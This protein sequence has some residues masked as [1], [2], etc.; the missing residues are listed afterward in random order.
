[1]TLQSHSWAYIQRKKMIRKETCTP[2][3]IAVL[4]TIAKMWKQ[5]KCPSTEEWIRICGTYIQWNITQP[6]KRM[7]SGHLQQ[8]RWA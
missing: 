2:L 6:L 4:L 1:M 5:P 7:K 3:F 8:H